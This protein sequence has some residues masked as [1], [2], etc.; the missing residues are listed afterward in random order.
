MDAIEAN[1]AG[2]HVTLYGDGIAPG[3]TTRVDRVEQSRLT[4]RD[5]AKLWLMVVATWIVGAGAV[6]LL[7]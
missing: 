5:N 7:S 3:L 1:Q 4:N 6:L 2:H